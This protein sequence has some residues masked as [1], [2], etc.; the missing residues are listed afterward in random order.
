[1][2]HA[3]LVRVVDGVAHAG[4]ELEPLSS[5]ETVALRVGRDGLAPHELHGEEG[6]RAGASVERTGLEDLRDA[7]VLQAPE[8]LDLVLEAALHAR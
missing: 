3:A 7:R 6:L 5:A 8:E 1:M 4:D 2:D